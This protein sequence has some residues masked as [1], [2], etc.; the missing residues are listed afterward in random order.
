MEMIGQPP[1]SMVMDRDP[2]D[3]YALFSTQVQRIRAL[4]KVMCRHNY[5]PRILSTIYNEF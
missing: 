4:P 5:R 3:F 2:D 1:M